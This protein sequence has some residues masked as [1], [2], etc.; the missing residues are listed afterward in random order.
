MNEYPHLNLGHVVFWIAQPF[1]QRWRLQWT[2]CWQSETRFLVKRLVGSKITWKLPQQKQQKAKRLLRRRASRSG[3]LSGS[4]K[5]FPPQRKKFE[6]SKFGGIPQLNSP[7]PLE[8]KSTEL[9]AND[10]KWGEIWGEHPPSPAALFF[11]FQA[12]PLDRWSGSSKV[13]YG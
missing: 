9:P 5:E 11:L 13:K 8:Q 10:S 12:W 2:I 3:K 7:I 6:V 1:S 4:L